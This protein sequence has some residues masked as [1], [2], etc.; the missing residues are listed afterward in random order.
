MNMLVKISED[1]FANTLVVSLTVVFL[2]NHVLFCFIGSNDSLTNF[3][4]LTLPNFTT[5]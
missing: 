3:L 1:I 5:L 2:K 4:G